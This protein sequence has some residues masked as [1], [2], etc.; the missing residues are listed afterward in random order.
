MSSAVPRP[1]ILLEQR[2]RRTC[3]LR[4]CAEIQSFSL[5]CHPEPAHAVGGALE[6]KKQ[7]LRT[8][9]EG[10]PSSAFG[11]FSPLRRGEGSR[12]VCVAIGSGSSRERKSRAF[13]LRLLGGRR[14]PTAGGDAASDEF[15]FWPA[16]IGSFL[17]R[18]A[19]VKRR[20]PCGKPRPRRLEQAAVLLPA[21]SSF[22]ARDPS[23]STRL[24]M[25]AL[26]CGRISAQR[27]S[28]HGRPRWLAK[29]W[30]CP[31]DVP[32]QDGISH[33][34]NAFFSTAA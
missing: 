25:T 28:R 11:T 5:A 1:A 3:R 6:N 19:G 4:V 34:W 17:E 16:N 32:A 33:R 13:S 21:R 30:A 10:D 9:H 29:P 31:P 8:C 18:E 15:A 27:L 12:C 14:W 2:A 23:P 22:L 26:G 24:R 7:N 20:I